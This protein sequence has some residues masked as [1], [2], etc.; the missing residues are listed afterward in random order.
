[1]LIY[2]HK[3]LTYNL[4]NDLCVSDS[5]KDIFTVDISRKNDKNILLS[6]CYRPP[7]GDSENLSRFLQNK[8]IEKSISQKKIS[9]IIGDIN[10]NCLK[11]Y[12]NAKTKDFYDNIFEKGSIPVI[13][14]PPRISE[15][16]A[17]L[18]DNILTTDIFNN[19]LKKR[20]N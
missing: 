13:N 15:H 4:R 10:M 17:S 3:S 2:T 1:M 5:D 14:C 12:E 7:N 9:Y 11:H 16:S 20:Y 6:Y 18:T 8:A 19:S